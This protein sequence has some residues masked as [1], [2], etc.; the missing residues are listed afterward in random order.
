MILRDE[1]AHHP[2]SSRNV[3]DRLTFAAARSI[4]DFTGRLAAP[5]PDQST[6]T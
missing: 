5:V 4:C 1:I 3:A 2:A 6:Q